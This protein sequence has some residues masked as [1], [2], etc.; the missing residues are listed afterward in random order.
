MRV[1]L[2]GTFN[3]LHAGHCALLDAA[4]AI[5]DE[6]CIAITSDDFISKTKKYHTPLEKRAER[7]DQYLSSK[8]CRY[9]ITV[10]DTP[11]GNAPYDKFLD[12]IVVSPETY[13][14][15][16]KINVS[17]ELNGLKPL[18]IV[19]VPHI[20]A[21]DGMPISSTRII[22][23]EIDTY[24]KML[25]PLKIAVGS[26]NK[27]KIDATRSAFLRF[28][29]NVEVFGV[30]V[31]SGVPEQPKESETRQGSI[32]RAKSCIGDADY[33]VG[34]EA[35]VFETEDGLYDVQYCS[36][37]DKAGKITI[38]HG[39]GFRYPD[40]VREKVEN[41]WTVGD[42]FNTMYEWERKGMGEGAIGCL[43]KGVVTRT[44]LSE[45]AVIAALVPRIKREMF[46]EI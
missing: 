6:V 15:A 1:G 13:E 36:I 24:G 18:E 44:Q 41:G 7:V 37:I 42:A 17:R 38:G 12:A 45:Q 9:S 22:S 20:L 14:N 8:K 28:Y 32:N 10:I 21:E 35:G 43:T 23:G 11:E 30:N 3:V 31:Q 4:A 34:L 39:P 19:T 2:G 25:R 29:E 33:G 46:P 5:G 16:V 40:A 26:L 27:I